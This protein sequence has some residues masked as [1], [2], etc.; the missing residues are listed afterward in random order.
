[1]YPHITGQEQP[2]HKRK[3]SSSEGPPPYDENRPYEYPSRPEPQHMANRAL[4]VLG[5][6]GHN[7]T[8]YYQNGTDPS[9]G[10]A[11]H[12]D[13][14]A[15]AHQPGNGVRPNTAEAHFVDELARE[16]DAQEA[17]PRPWDHPPPP[18]WQANPDQYGHDPAQA[19]TAITPKRKRNFSNRT[20]TGCITCRDRKKKC[21]EA[22][23]IC[24]F[25]H[26]L[27]RR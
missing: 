4:H 1:M 21:D 13:R 19:V 18:D 15:P 27:R 24:E 10:H 16:A 12:A 20:K 8:A 3:R 26:F 2:G 9:N 6:G 7:T 17:Q 23:P 5:N 14:P 11:W 22:R 25:A